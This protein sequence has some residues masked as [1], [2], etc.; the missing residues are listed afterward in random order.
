[1]HRW[2]NKC[3]KI[4]FALFLMSINSFSS[5][6]CQTKLYLCTGKQQQNNSRV[7]IGMSTIAFL[8]S[9]FSQQTDNRTSASYSLSWEDMRQRSQHHQLSQQRMITNHS[10]SGWNMETSVEANVNDDKEI[11]QCDWWDLTF[12]GGA[13]VRSWA[14]IRHLIGIWGY[15]KILMIPWSMKGASNVDLLFWHRVFMLVAGL[16]FACGR[17]CGLKKFT[18]RA[19]VL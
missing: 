17:H 12:A 2:R 9:L 11:L 8:T 6:C 14:A 10:T 15:K 1:M 4:H 19:A 18:M 13:Y 5:W 16:K 7:S 3:D